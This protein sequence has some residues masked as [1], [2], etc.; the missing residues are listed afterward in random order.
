MLL[1][2]L[3]QDLRE[4]SAQQMVSTLGKMQHSIF[5]IYYYLLKLNPL[6]IEQ[7]FL[8]YTSVQSYIIDNRGCNSRT[9]YFLSHIDLFKLI[10]NLN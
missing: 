9:I 6:Y 5:Q 4:A 7:L 2:C 10:I 8:L 1:F 3:G